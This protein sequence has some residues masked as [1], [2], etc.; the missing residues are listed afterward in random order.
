MDES[1]ATPNPRRQWFRIAFICTALL[2]LVGGTWWWLQPRALLDKAKDLEI[3][4]S[5]SEVER[6]MGSTGYVLKLG[7]RWETRLFGPMQTAILKATQAAQSA[8]GQS[9]PIPAVAEWPVAV[10]FDLRTGKCISIRRGDE[11]V[12][13]KSTK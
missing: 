2:V 10:E 4:Q 9:V 1:P 5:I 7:N 11:V 8:T 3:G 12:A 6:I 13:A